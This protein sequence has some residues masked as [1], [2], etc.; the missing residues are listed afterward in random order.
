LSGAGV[1]L[2][3]VCADVAKFNLFL[4]YSRREGIFGRGRREK[5]HFGELGG[6]LRFVG[7]IP[8]SSLYLLSLLFLAFISLSSQ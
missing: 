4:F 7:T 2:S 6:V 1:A 8:S 3:D 5:T